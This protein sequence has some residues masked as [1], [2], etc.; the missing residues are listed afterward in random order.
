MFLF[1][2]VSG[3]CSEGHMEIDNHNYQ[4]ALQPALQPD[5]PALQPDQPALQPDQPALQPDQ[6]ALQPDQPAYDDNNDLNDGHA[7]PGIT[8]MYYIYYYKN[9]YTILSIIPTVSVGTCLYTS[10]HSINMLRNISK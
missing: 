3:F 7:E 1:S 9:L 6:L 5:Q 4:P 8:F 10:Y 2:Y